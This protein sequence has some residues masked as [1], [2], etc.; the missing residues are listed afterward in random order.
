ML[1]Q[2]GFKLV[3]TDG[4][5][6]LYK[7]WSIDRNSFVTITK[8]KGYYRL[9]A[10]VNNQYAVLGINEEAL[11]DICEKVFGF[12]K[13]KV[14]VI[15]FDGTL[16]VDS[17]YPDIAPIRMDAA[18]YTQKLYSEG[19][20]IIINTAREGEAL[21]AAIRFLDRY[22]VKYDLVND[23]APFKVKKFN[24]NCRKVTGDVV[25]DDKNLGGIPNDWA[26]IYKTILKQV[27]HL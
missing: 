12:G 2:Y 24:N 13:A 8:T 23:N 20:Y 21:D 18:F 4:N 9:D 3:E 6:E 10:N 26:T 14:I 25:I 16:T 22:N 1:K 27:K 11:N 5:I 7:R 19:F 15:D 17:E